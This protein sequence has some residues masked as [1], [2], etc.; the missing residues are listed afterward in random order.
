MIAKKAF[1]RTGHDSTRVIFGAAA[2]GSATQAEADRTLEV[3]LSHGINHIDTAA[4][5]GDAEL[6][7]GPWMARHRADFF[8][9]TKTGKRTYSEAKEEI[10]RSLERLR[11]DQVDLLQLHCLVDPA[12]WETAFGDDG[13]V[14]AVVEARDQGLARF[15]GVTG[16]GITVAKMHLQSLERFDFDSV[17]LPY[18]YAM[19]SQPSY[20]ADFEAVM[21]VCKARNVAVQTIKG[22]C[23]RPWPSEQ[24]SWATW[25]EPFAEDADIV[26]AVS[27]ALA[28]EQIFLNTPADTKLLPKVLAAASSLGTAPSPEEMQRFAATSDLRPLFS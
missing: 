5:Y 7:L 24:R 19:M 26:R 13:A 27:W 12:K 25:Y 21:A 9:A 11:V 4:S 22:V 28:R 20:A 14:R 8:L 18:N 16:H 17:L 23:R 10:L 1:G 6:R 2:L 15:V 3:L